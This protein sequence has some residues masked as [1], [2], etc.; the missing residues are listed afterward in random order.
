LVPGAA[1]QPK[2]GAAAM[3]G[4]SLEKRL[5]SAFQNPALGEGRVTEEVPGSA[6]AK[7]RAAIAAAYRTPEPE[8]IPPLIQQARLEP[9]ISAPAAAFARKLVEILRASRSHGFGVEALMKEFSLSSREGV[10]L[11]CLAESLLRIPDRETRDLLIRDKLARGD[12]GA[13]V[14]AS[15]SWLVNAS[16]WGLL[17]TGKLVATH[18]EPGMAASL[19]RVLARGGEPVIRGA[20]D[21]AMRL[22]GRQFVTGQTIEE[23]LQHA[24]PYEARGFFYSFDMLGEAAVTAVDAA[25]YNASYEKAIKAIGAAKHGASVYNSAGISVKL[26]ALHPRYSYMQ[27]DRV[28]EELYPR[29]RSLAL[30]ASEQGIGFNIDAEEADRLEPS[31]D[32][33]EMLASDASLGGWQGLGFVVQAYQKRAPF[34]IEHLLSL[35]ERS[36][37]RLMIRLVKG[38]YWDSEIKQAQVDGLSGFPVFTRKSYTDVCYLACAKR[39]LAWRDLVFPQF[40]THNAHTLSAIYH[41]AGADFSLGDYEFQCLHGMGETLYSHVVGPDKPGRPCRI[42][43]PVGTHETL[44]AYLVRRLLENGANSSFVHQLADDKIPI[45]DLIADPLEEAER[46]AGAPHSAI[47]LPY[48]LFGKERDNS[49]GVDLSECSARGRLED[50]VADSRK[51]VFEAGP[52]VAFA[53]RASGERWPIRNPANHVDIVGDATGS[54]PADIE[55]AMVA[56]VGACASWAATAAAGRAQLLERAAGLLERSMD[57]LCAL[58][59]R[60]AGRTMPN[61]I[62]EVREAVD[63]C[64][65]Y[66]V[67]A[68]ALDASRESLGPAVCISPWNFPLAIFT[69]QIAAALAAG[70]PVLAKPAGQTPLIA[71]QAVRIFHEAG[72]PLDALQLLPGPGSV[73]ALLVADPRT[74]AVLF[75]GSTGVARL[76][77]RKLAEKGNIPFIAETGGQNAMIVDSS[78][79]PEQ[80]VTDVLASAF[81]SAGQRCSALRVLCLQDGIAD[82]VLG[83]LKG[84]MAEIRLGDPSLIETD[85]GPVIDAGAQAALNAYIASNKGR[86]LC[87]TPMPASLPPGTF[88]APALLE[89]GSIKELGHEVFGPVLHVVRFA[90]GGLGR[91]IDEINGTGYGLTLGIH[92]RIDET[93]EFVAARARV[94]N[95]YVNRNMIGAVVGVQPFG[96]EGLSGTGPKAGGPFY[97]HRLLRKGTPPR[98]NGE[99]EETKLEA[100]NSLAAWLGTGAS[101][102]LKNDE[103]ARLLANLKHYRETTPLPVTITLPGPVGEDNRLSFSPRGRV[104]GI[105]S[106]NF[107]ALDQFGAALATGNRFVLSYA[108]GFGVL[109]ERIPASLLPYVEFADN[110]RDAGPDAV[111][112]ANQSK[113]DEV[114]LALAERDGPLIQI[115]EPSPHYGLSRLVKEKT[116]SINTTAAGGNASLMTIDR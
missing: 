114:L 103:P 65:Y 32:L 94:G 76:I 84:A 33:L 36:K 4:S 113:L 12:W 26:S 29:L 3:T 99:R 106:A 110:W 61:A 100:L 1:S 105:A 74:E 11:M 18:S 69:G 56:A 30:L 16:A 102:L 101:G 91:L 10:A 62:S 28:R 20:M 71:A 60:E 107:D 83:M 31:L 2:A 67:Q 7:T 21:L 116:V 27:M 41:M 51:I 81:D 97:L 68:R 90:R 57:R 88:V 109:R 104:L 44:L 19:G 77:Q 48:D 111:L 54:T 98:L 15:P 53:K 40:A 42:Y 79:L 52:L 73:G 72:I 47:V 22:L 23:A 46:Y 115:E 93:I 92:S 85:I 17:I 6:F 86:I 37:H 59:V 14:G 75:T 24:R 9:A 5:T 43:A 70:N 25:R 39:L 45:E 66:A 78:A 108:E 112:L 35:A 34:V 58:I 13:H 80:A 96:G 87:R 63:F 64:R 89:I 95:I 82:R 55:A 8:S 49:R 38:A 50:A